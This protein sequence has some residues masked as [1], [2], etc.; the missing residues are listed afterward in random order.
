ML[1]HW[2][3]VHTGTVNESGPYYGFLSGAG[4]DI[5][6]VTLIGAVIGTYKHNNCASPHCFRLGRHPTADGLH[7][8]CRHH[9]PD[10]MGKKRTLAE[11]HAAHWKAKA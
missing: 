11:I 1:Q 3:A 7:R 8:L 9:H 2:L 4:S 10:L 5:G 6:E